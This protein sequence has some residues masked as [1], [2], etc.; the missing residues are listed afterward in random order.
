MDV[1]KALSQFHSWQLH[2]ISPKTY[3]NDVMLR[4]S[5]GLSSAEIDAAVGLLKTG[6]CYRCK[7]ARGRYYFAASAEDAARAAIAGEQKR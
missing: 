4:A 5:D 6:S 1:I 3:T 2:R 7:I